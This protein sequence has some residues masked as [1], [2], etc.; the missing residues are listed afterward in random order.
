MP[1]PTPKPRRVQDRFALLA[2]DIDADQPL[3]FAIWKFDLAARRRRIARHDDA[4][5]LAAAKVKN[6]AGR[7]V[8]ARQAEIGVDAALEPVTR[9]GDD[10]KLAA[11]VGDIGWVPERA[12]DQHVAGGLVAAGMLA[13]HDTGNRF[14]PF[15]V[16]DHDHAL[17]KRVGLAVERHQALALTGAPHGQVAR[18]FGEVKD[19][20][21]PAAIEGDV[22]GDVDER[23]DRPEADR[24][25]TLLHPDRGRPIGYAAHEPQGESGA[26]I[27][28]TRGELEID[29]GR[30]VEDALDPFRRR[31][32]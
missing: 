7:E 26:E 2:R 28:V 18:D 15:C 32:S 29:A 12:L 23:A 11:G 30:A 22:I 4:R 27:G 8:A 24:P 16:S 21:R 20:Q 25:K 17:V 19:V 5:G 9:I 13:A 14:D 6:E 1:S 3:D 31:S 10:T